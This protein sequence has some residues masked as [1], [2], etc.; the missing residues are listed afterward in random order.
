[1]EKLQFDLRGERTFSNSFL[2]LGEFRYS[3]INYNDEE[4]ESDGTLGTEFGNLTASG[5]VKFFNGP[6]T[7][8]DTGS[9]AIWGEY[10]G[11]AVFVAAT[12]DSNHY[13][14]AAYF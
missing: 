4:L 7:I 14:V 8:F 10:V 9:F 13:G 6:L 3:F 2:R 12:H 11:V 5:S 1:M